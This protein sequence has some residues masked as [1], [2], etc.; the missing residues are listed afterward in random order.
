VDDGGVLAR[1][2]FEGVPLGGVVYVYDVELFGVVL[3]LFEVV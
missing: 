2:V 1:V 3:G